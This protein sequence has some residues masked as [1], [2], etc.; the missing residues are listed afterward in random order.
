MEVGFS[1]GFGQRPRE[2]TV[3]AGDLARMRREIER[4]KRRF[5]LSGETPFEVPHIP[6]WNR[7]LSPIPEIFAVHVEA[8]ERDNKE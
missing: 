3:S 6:N 8:V 1:V 2:R 7:V 5:G 4:A